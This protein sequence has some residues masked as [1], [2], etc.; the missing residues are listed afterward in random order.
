MNRFLLLALA[1]PLFASSASARPAYRRALAELLDLP[2]SSRLNDCRTC[3]LPLQPGA[4]EKDRPHNAFGARLKAV[5][6]ALRKSGKPTDIAAR[7][8]HIAAEDSD[9]D[10]VANLHELLAGT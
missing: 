4:D 5:R 8:L 2:S 6:S 7:I 1:L 3:H 9:K 10:G